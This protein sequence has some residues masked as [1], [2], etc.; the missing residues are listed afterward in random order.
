MAGCNTLSYTDSTLGKDHISKLAEKIPK[1][2]HTRAC[3]KGTTANISTVF[4]LHVTLSSL[5]LKA[6]SS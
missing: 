4:K 1:T 2:K 6:L 5:L 3:E